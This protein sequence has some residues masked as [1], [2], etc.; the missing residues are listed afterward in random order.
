MCVQRVTL[1]VMYVSVFFFFFFSFVIS[2][3]MEGAYKDKICVSVWARV[4]VCEYLGTLCN[5]WYDF[6]FFVST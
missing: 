6:F 2:I 3:T 5:P 1:Q 4:S